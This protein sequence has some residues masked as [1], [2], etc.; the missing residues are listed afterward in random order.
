MSDSLGSPWTGAHQPSL[1]FTISWSLLRFMSTES[2]MLFTISPS[3]AVFPSCPQSFS[4][5]GSFPVS[6]LFTSGGQSTEASVSASV[7]VMSTQGWFSKGLTDLISL[8]SKGLSKSY[9]APQ[10]ESISSLMLTLLYGPNLT[11]IY[12]YWKNNSS[13]FFDLYWQS[14]VSAF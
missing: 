9:P 5:S 7:L 10:F 14:N 4:E 11:F 13:D 12:D 1:S 2:V 3:V 6:Q 8:L